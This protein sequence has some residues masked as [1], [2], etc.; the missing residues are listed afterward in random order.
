[1]PKSTKN[2]VIIL[3]SLGLRVFF[4]DTIGPSIHINADGNVYLDP[5]GKH[6]ANLKK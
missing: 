2:P 4:D 6:L 3:T 1:M 5:A